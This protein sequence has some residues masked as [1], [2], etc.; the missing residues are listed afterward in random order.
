M[1]D[2]VSKK[3]RK[4]WEHHKKSNSCHFNR[5]ATATFKTEAI[6]DFIYLSS[7]F[8]FLFYKERERE[9]KKQALFGR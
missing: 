7:N 1:T 2:F 5:A 4:R 3:L 6:F 9:K 8:C